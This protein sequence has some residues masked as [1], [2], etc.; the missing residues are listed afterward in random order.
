MLKLTGLLSVSMVREKVEYTILE[1]ECVLWG[2]RLQ[3]VCD[4][5]S[6]PEEE[7]DNPKKQ[8]E[9][10]EVG[11]MDEGEHPFPFEFGLPAKSMPSSIDVRSV[12]HTP[13]SNYSSAK[14]RLRI[15]FDVFINDHPRF[16]ACAVEPWPRRISQ[17]STSSMSA[18]C[19]YPSP[20]EVGNLIMSR[21]QNTRATYNLKSNSTKRA[22]S[23]A[24][25]YD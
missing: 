17:Y 8:K 25:K 22:T 1:Q 4:R 20:S 2:N 11:T 15:P 14:D 19:G 3:V 6:S 7:Y 5:T 10:W 18:K 13:I 21:N 24:K 9:V 23:K 16:L 12:V